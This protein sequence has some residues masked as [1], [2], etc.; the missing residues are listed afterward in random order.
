ME[1]CYRY[2][3]VILLKTDIPVNVIATNQIITDDGENFKQLNFRI[4][5]VSNLKINELSNVEWPNLQVTKIG[6]KN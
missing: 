5:D 4:V 6:N 3:W 1:S 2:M